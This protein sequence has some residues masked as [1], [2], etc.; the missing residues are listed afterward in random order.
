MTGNRWLPPEQASTRLGRET[1]GRETYPA[2]EA[3]G[4]EKRGR[5]YRDLRRRAAERSQKY[6]QRSEEPEA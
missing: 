5:T 1:L 4:T 3:S 2:P 6:V